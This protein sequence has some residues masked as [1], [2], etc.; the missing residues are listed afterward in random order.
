MTPGYLLSFSSRRYGTPGSM[1]CTYICWRWM[2]TVALLLVGTP[3]VKAENGV[4]LK[5]TLQSDLGFQL[6][7]IDQTPTDPTEVLVVG[8]GLYNAAAFTGNS[9]LT[10]NFRTTQLEQAKVD[11]S[12]DLGLLY[13]T[14][15]TQWQLYNPSASHGI[16]LG[17][18]PL[19]ADLR[20]LSCAFFFP[21][22][23]LIIGRQIVNFGT[24]MVFSPIDV[25]T[26][27]DLLELSFRRRGSDVVRLRSS[28]NPTSG[29][30][31]VTSLPTGLDGQE[32]QSSA[33][34]LFTHLGGWDLSGIAL[35]RNPTQE[36]M[37][38]LA[39]KGDLLL[40]ISGE[41]VLHGQEAQ[42]EV[43]VELMVGADYS[44]NNR[45]FLNAEYYYRDE[46]LG[47][48]SFY[49]VHNVFASVRLTVNDLLSVSLAGLGSFPA[50][51]QL[52]T[53]QVAYNVFQGVDA[54]FYV[55]GYHIAGYEDL[56]PQ[57]EVAVRTMV[58]F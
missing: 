21:N 56:L 32:T 51:S 23:D 2:L 7:H 46:S 20:K 12:L 9:L 13:G 47:A 38:G 19:F 5:G 43:P 37:G 24:G 52:L 36:W 10:L 27:V 48:A 11:A 53:A 22:T 50:E 28:F 39:F 41:L 44:L 15:A 29:M 49:D 55:R 4:Q 34:K 33:L 31:L 26:Q 6:A 45:W 17:T 25:F 42:S 30:E 40:G 1:Q 35:Y 3:P 14:A 54:I 57:S 8:G 58:K 18:T 16:F